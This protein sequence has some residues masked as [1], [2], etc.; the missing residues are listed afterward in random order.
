[1]LYKR[2]PIEKESPE[3][4]GYGNIHYNL[5]ESSVTDLTIGE[6]NLSINDLTL[7]YTGH[8][9][10]PALRELIVQD[11][12]NLD[13]ENVLLTNGAAGALFII[14]SSLLTADD[15]L[16]VVRPNYAT[17]IEVPSTIGCSIS[18][19]DLH[20]ETEWKL[21]VAEIEAAIQPSTKLIS[22]TTPHNPTGMLMSEASIDEIIL[23][24]ERHNIHLLVDETYR[25]ACF[26]T[27]YPLA[28]TKSNKVITVSSLSKA[29]G[30]PGLR[31]GWLITLDEVMMER[32]LAAKEMI[33]I[34][35]SVLDEEV[36]YQFYLQK[37]IFATNINKKCLQN[38]ELLK[39]WLQKETRMECILPEGGVVCFARF[40]K[41]LQIDT[42]RFYDIL[43]ATYHTMVGPGHW[44]GMPD[45][46]M[47]IGFGWTT[48]LI[49]QQGLQ[50]I[51]A[52][53][54]ASLL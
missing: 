3:E 2:M 39:E 8:R 26:K 20:F 4:I 42:N 28:A 18:F 50:N 34:S 9:G 45:T 32:F 22:I 53:I 48:D 38:F 6:L 47:R 17:N 24:A 7:E 35:N 51:S 23:I 49:L 44:F 1:M 31:I 15:H 30:L 37:E 11:F 46:Y 12:I 16:I 10:K 21:D 54:D 14:N 41:E 5:S 27:P 36:A 33:Y 29:F 43:M 19:I 52:A 13:K 25:D 40:K